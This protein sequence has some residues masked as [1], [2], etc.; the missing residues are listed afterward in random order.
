MTFDIST[1]AIARA[2]VAF[3]GGLV[4]IMNWWHDRAVG[5]AFWWAV[6][7]CGTGVGIAL[8]AMH[9]VL[10]DWATTVVGPLVLDLCGALTWVAARIFTRGSVKPLVVIAAIGGWLVL[11]CAATKSAGVQHAVALGVAITACLYCAAAV[12]FWL[13][14]AEKLRGRWPM[15]SILV[16]QSIA[17]LLASI[18]YATSN[19]TLPT[20]G[21]FGIIH[22][23]GLIYVGGAAIFLTM[24]LNERSEIKYKAAALIDPLTGLANRRAFMERAQQTFDR[25]LRDGVPISLIAVDLDRFKNVNDDF[26]HHVGDHVL[27]IFADVLSK[28]LRPADMAGRMGGEEFVAILPGCEIEAAL[29]VARRIRSAFQDDARFVDGHRVEATLSAGVA[30]APEPGAGLTEMMARAD[31]A[32]Y[33]AKNQGR[34]RVMRAEPYSRDL[35]SATVIRIA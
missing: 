24:M 27:R 10:P 4:L 5:A 29:V 28:V 32:M 7:L 13:G 3:A 19:L 8:L 26:G 23:I 9:S 33:A 1:L 31:A 35:Q 6:V 2:I 22:F 21:W 17:L 34:N 15:V 11:L 12:E 18:Q 30:G 20:V 25:C 16:L 14:R